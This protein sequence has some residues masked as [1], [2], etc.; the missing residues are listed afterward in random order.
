MDYDR[1]GYIYIVYI[2]CSYFEHDKN[3]KTGISDLAYL[4]GIEKMKFQVTVLIIDVFDQNGNKVSKDIYRN[5]QS[6]L[7]HTLDT[8]IGSRTWKIHDKDAIK[9]LCQCNYDESY[10]SGFFRI[11]KL[12]WNIKLYPNGRELTQFEVGDVLLQIQLEEL[13]KPMIGLSFMYRFHIKECNTWYSNI[14]HFRNSGDNW[15][16]LR[17]GW[18]LSHL[19]TNTI[20]SLEKFSLKLEI[21]ILEVYAEHNI[22]MTH[23][24]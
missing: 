1:Y 2:V 19:K 8:K 21:K 9:M 3:I 14:A 4:S 7:K 13:I 5:L 20:K 12:K 11:N 6:P 22:V 10:E 17:D 16:G 23:V 24:Y 15:N 18:F